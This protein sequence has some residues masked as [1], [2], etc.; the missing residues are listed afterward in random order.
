VAFRY[1]DVDLLSDKFGHR[2]RDSFVASPE[3]TMSR[4]A[5]L[6]V[7][8]GFLVGLALGCGSSKPR[9]GGGGELPAKEARLA[10]LEKAIAAKEKEVADLKAEADGLSKAIAQAGIPKDAPDSFSATDLQATAAWFARHAR[11]IRDAERT[12]N[13]IRVEEAVDD[14]RRQVKAIEGKEVRWKLTVSYIGERYGEIYVALEHIDLDIRSPLL[15]VLAVSGVDGDSLADII[16]EHEEEELR[17]GLDPTRF[18]SYCILQLGKGFPR[19]RAAK[20][21]NRDTITLT[22]TVKDC[23]LRYNPVYRLFAIGLVR[24]KVVD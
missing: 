18:R 7:L 5:G 15:G 4:F 20:L 3:F 2:R 19:E 10:E 23:K 1:L 17:Y 21:K 11:R 16:R 6:A 12:H 13:A 9:E 8:G 24:A 22:G 14:V